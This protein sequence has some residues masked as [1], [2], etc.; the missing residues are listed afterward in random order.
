MVCTEEQLVTQ[1][2]VEG[3]STCGANE[4]QLG[5]LGLQEQPRIFSRGGGGLFITKDTNSIA[6]TL[7]TELIHCFCVS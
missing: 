3:V 7:A 5:A 4:V 2:L 1:E 6:L